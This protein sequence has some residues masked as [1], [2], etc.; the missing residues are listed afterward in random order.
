ME[1]PDLKAKRVNPRLAI[2]TTEVGMS[3]IDR[4]VEDLVPGNTVA[5]TRLGG[6]ALGGD[7]EAPC[8]V[9]YLDRWALCLGVRV[10]KRLGLS[11]DTLRNLAVRRFLRQHQVSVVLGEFLDQFLEFIPLL[12]RMNIPFV[13]QGH[14]IDV[15]AKLRLPKLRAEYLAYQS[16]RAVLTRSEF[17]R[18]RLVSIGI[19]QEKVHVNPGGVDVPA[20]MPIRDP[21]AAKRFLSLGRLATKKGPIYLMEAFRLAA[22]KD[23]EIELD[24]VGN[25]ALFPAVH[26]FVLACGLQD[27]VRLHGYASEA[28]KQRLLVK[29]GVF[30]QHSITDPDTGDEEGLPAATQE[31]MAYAMAVVSTRHAGIPEAVTHGETGLLVDEGDVRAMSEAMLDVIRHVPEFGAAARRKAERL[32]TWSAERSRLLG[33]LG[34]E[35]D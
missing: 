28:L 10:A 34:V 11:E 29:C 17:H 6:H 25:G 14:G 30:V 15:S 21:K 12:Q 33:H 7:W 1:P 19:P 31:A 32:Y 18:Q 24:V 8:P 35:I 13:A 26:Q 27:R 20:A 23:T 5:I 4:H 3:F 22:A 2:I 16:A 9:M